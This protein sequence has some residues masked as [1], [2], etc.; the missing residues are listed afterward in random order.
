MHPPFCMHIWAGHGIQKGAEKIKYIKCVYSYLHAECGVYG[1]G[2]NYTS[3][4]LEHNSLIRAKPHTPT[5]SPDQTQACKQ[6]T[7]SCVPCHPIHS[8]VR[9]NDGMRPRAPSFASQNVDLLLYFVVSCQCDFAWY[10]NTR[11][12][13]SHGAVFSTSCM[14]TVCEKHGTGVVTDP[15][16][17]A[18]R[19]TWVISKSLVTPTFFSI[20]NFY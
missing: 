1:G 3:G 6:N 11:D 7:R 19:A 5:H 15:W 13:D 8:F 9:D 14:K 4:E 2:K 12:R 16:Y 17:F 10:L 18:F 20:L